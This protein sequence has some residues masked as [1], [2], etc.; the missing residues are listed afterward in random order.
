MSL[1]DFIGKKRIKKSF[2]ESIFS[3]KKLNVTLLRG[4][5]NLNH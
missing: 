5:E 3:S 1:E 2:T 4:L